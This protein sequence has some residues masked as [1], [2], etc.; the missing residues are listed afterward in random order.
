M[1]VRRINDGFKY[2][3]AAES[4]RPGYLKRRFAQYRKRQQDKPLP[5]VVPMKAKR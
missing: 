4:E 5:N 3:S 2:H 1:S